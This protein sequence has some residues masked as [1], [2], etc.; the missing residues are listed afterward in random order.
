MCVHVHRCVYTPPTLEWAGGLLGQGEVLVTQVVD[1]LVLVDLHTGANVTLPVE[2]EGE[3][4]RQVFT[5]EGEKDRAR[6]ECVILT[7]MAHSRS[8][9]V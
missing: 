5:V 2:E 3:R 9:C 4:A 1:R 8:G 6:T 7:R